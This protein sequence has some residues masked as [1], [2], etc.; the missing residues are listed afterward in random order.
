MKN[1]KEKEI[2]TS[3]QDVCWNMTLLYNDQSKGYFHI[4][5]YKYLYIF[6]IYL[7]FFL[8]GYWFGGCGKQSEI[9]LDCNP[10]FVE[11][12]N[13]DFIC[14]HCS[15]D[16]C[17]L[18]K[19]IPPKNSTDATGTSSTVNQTQNRAI[20]IT[21]LGV[22]IVGL[23]MFSYWKELENQ[24]RKLH[25]FHHNDEQCKMSREFAVSKNLHEGLNFI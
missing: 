9:E 15:E 5:I 8:W 19:L 12:S 22:A 1:D 14:N 24:Q 6:F 2:C 11:V 7:F 17:N 25:K 4:I 23:L 13:S 10:H 20:L 21:L 3:N 16:G 18:K